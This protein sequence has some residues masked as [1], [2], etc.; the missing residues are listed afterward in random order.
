MFFR[1][2][3]NSVYFK[4]LIWHAGWLNVAEFKNNKKRE[5]VQVYPASKSNSISQS[6]THDISTKLSFLFSF[7]T[8]LENFWN[9][10]T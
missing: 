2:K 1:F 10:I 9:F 6:L 7:K 4:P 8:K 3:M 5:I